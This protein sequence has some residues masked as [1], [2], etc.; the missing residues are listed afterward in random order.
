MLKE[1]GRRRRMVGAVGFEPT[2]SC[3]QGRHANQAA[4]RPDTI[5]RGELPLLPFFWIICNLFAVFL[6]FSGC[7]YESVI[8]F[9][10]TISAGYKTCNRAD[11]R[12][13]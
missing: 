9:A 10:S 4:L 8:F 13:T 6:S 11:L 7:H 5:Y 2:T 1:G 12:K 3:S